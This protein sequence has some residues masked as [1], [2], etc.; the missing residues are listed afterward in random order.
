MHIAASKKDFA[1]YSSSGATTPYV[2]SVPT[3][4][5]SDCSVGATVYYV[6]FRLFRERAY[7]IHIVPWA[8]ICYSN[9]SVGSHITLQI[10]P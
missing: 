3:V 9:G 5:Y 6:V 10:V 4:H 8:C 1:L 7:A 2:M